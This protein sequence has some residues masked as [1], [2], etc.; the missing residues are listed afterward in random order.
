MTRASILRRHRRKAS[1]R[2][3]RNIDAVEMVLF[4]SGEPANDE[5]RDER[6]R[7]CEKFRKLMLDWNAQR[8]EVLWK[9]LREARHE[10]DPDVDGL[11]FTMAFHDDVMALRDVEKDEYTM[12][13]RKQAQRIP[14]EL[15]PWDPET[16]AEAEIL[17]ACLA[18][19][20]GMRVF[21]GQAP[22]KE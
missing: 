5:C 4:G 14:R 22:G 11:S 1:K 10:Y 15:D 9:W 8:P 6:K 7:L 21:S 3:G 20:K 12:A 13:K 18:V 17:E 16:C 2:E 19:E